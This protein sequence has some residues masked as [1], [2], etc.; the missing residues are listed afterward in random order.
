MRRG[1]TLIELLVVIAIIA[2]LIAIL[3]PT[4][5]S[6]RDAARTLACLA[7]VRTLE[8][9]HTSYHDENDGFFVDAGIDHGGVGDATKSWPFVLSELSG[10]QI[11]LR[12]PVDRSPRWPIDQGGQDTGFALGTYLALKT[13]GDPSNDPPETRLARWTS[14]GLNNFLTRSKAPDSSIY[15]LD[16]PRYDAIQYIQFPSATVH[17]LQMTQGLD[18]ASNSFAVADHIHVEDWAKGRDRDPAGIAATQV[19]TNAHGGKPGS[20][21]ARANYGFLD[22]HAETLRFE[23]VYETWQA[24]Q[25]NP[26]VA[27]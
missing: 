11:A 25:M 5:A 26:D 7:N 22:G 8:I 16:R 27:N 12:S 19:D 23:Q 13:D 4:L 17:F 14:Y 21:A 6:A 10:Q 2:I 18:D 20:R 24:N 3:L 9:A 15:R 1:F